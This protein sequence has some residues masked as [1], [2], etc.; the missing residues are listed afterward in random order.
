MTE[1]QNY[2]EAVTIYISQL[3]NLYIV[4][5]DLTQSKSVTRAAATI[6]SELLVERVE[7]IVESSQTVGEMTTTYLESSDQVQRE[8]SEIRML[9][10]AIASLELA[11]DLLE[12]AEAEEEGSSVEVTCSGT[13]GSESSNSI[14][15]LINLLEAP[16][17]AGIPSALMPNAQVRGAAQRPNDVKQAKADLEEEVESSL[18]AICEQNIF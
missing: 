13:R 4:P 11:K 6:P 1:Q 5:E 3:R 18:S 9:A 10:Q 16:I 7:Q 14:E 8:A 12:R 2:R 15:N 17:E